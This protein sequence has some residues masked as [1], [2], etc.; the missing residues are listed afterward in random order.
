MS[1]PLS[2]PAQEIETMSAVVPSKRPSSPQLFNKNEEERLRRKIIDL[3]TP[4]MIEYT[5]MENPFPTQTQLTAKVLEVINTACGNK[6]LLLSDGKTEHFKKD[7]IILD[8][9]CRP[10]NIFENSERL[11]AFCLILASRYRGRN[12]ISIQELC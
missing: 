9:V 12:K 3:A 10:L 6:R 8:K 4:A 2:A 5:L 7:K 11:K 1:K